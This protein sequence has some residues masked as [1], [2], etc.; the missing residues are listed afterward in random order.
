MDSAIV[1]VLQYV[2]NRKPKVETDISLLCEIERVKSNLE[3]V[4]AH[5]DF[6]SDPDL[7]D[8]CIYEMKSLNSRYRYLLRE[9]K[10]SGITGDL[11]Q[12][13]EHMSRF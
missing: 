10:K 13:I 11:I 9:A 2:T 4:A 8:A 1:G 5:F 3:T 7:V 12:N 6:E